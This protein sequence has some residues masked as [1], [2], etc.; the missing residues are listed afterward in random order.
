MSVSGTY[1]SKF[2]EATHC[3]FN[4]HLDA[5]DFRAI[6]IQRV[7]DRTAGAVTLDRSGVL[8]IKRKGGKECVALTYQ[9]IF[10]KQSTTGHPFKGDN[11]KLGGEG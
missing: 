6:A 8:P 1:K 2:A 4:G 9:G 5:P 10:G 3:L 7:V 11:T